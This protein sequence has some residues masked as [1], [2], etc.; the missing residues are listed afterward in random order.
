MLGLLYDVHGNLPALEAVLDDARPLGV[1]RWVVGGD[2]GPL[3]GWPAE[4][5]ARL[6]ELA[7]ATWVRGNWERWLRDSSDRPPALAAATAAAVE[8]LGE[9][10]VEELFALPQS[11]TV[12]DTTYSH[13]SPLSDMRSFL[14]E[15]ADDEDEL[16]AAAAPGTRR[17]VFGHTHLQFM[18]AARGWPD[19][20]LV[21]PGSVG[22]PFD[23]DVRA[24]W[25]VVHDDGAVELRRVAYDHERAA[26]GVVERFGGAEWA[27]G[28][29]ARI[30]AARFQP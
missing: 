17:L 29:A 21:N 24:A 1:G 16:L 13:G 9:A 19:V 27:H 22:L 20:E 2:I 6:R 7:D 12:G 18:R 15:P 30:M 8:A 25:A 4:C 14:P 10:Q 23:G 26:A 28:T 3:G 5:V 11:V